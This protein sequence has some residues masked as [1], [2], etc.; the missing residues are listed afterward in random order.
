MS[1]GKLIK[2]VWK[3]C[4]NYL[5]KKLGDK[6]TVV[7][8]FEKDFRFQKT[9]NVLCKCFCEDAFEIKKKNWKNSF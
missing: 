5:F 2:V 3:L 1:K 7:E 4:G 6:C 9:A 8:I